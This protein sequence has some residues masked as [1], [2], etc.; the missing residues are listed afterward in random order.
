[1]SKVNHLT[2][3]GW[4][5]IYTSSKANAQ[6]ILTAP[7]HLVFNFL[8]LFNLRQK[9][10]WKLRRL[11]SYQIEVKV[12]LQLGRIEDFE[13]YFWDLARSFPWAP[14]AMKHVVVWEGQQ[15]TRK[16]WITWAAFDFWKTQDWDCMATVV[17]WQ[18]CAS[19]AWSRRGYNYDL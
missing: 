5:K 8:D 2:C 17:H 12:I 9:V 13:R 1:M 19:S 4:P 16:V 11:R 3:T 6:H 14:R 10:R 7:V 15:R 18:Y